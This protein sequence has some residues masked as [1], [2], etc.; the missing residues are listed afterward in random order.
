MLRTQHVMKK[1]H[2][3]PSALPLGT[4]TVDGDGV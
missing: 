4:G 2:Q 1:K 3:W